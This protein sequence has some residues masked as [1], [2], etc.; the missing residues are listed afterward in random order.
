M[1]EKS[2][3]SVLGKWHK[4][5]I[6]SYR[7]ESPHFVQDD[8]LF[9]KWIDHHVAF[10]KHEFLRLKVYFSLFFFIYFFIL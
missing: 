9:E 4:D 3:I 7:K 5:D 1:D 2:M 6:K 8:R 10:L